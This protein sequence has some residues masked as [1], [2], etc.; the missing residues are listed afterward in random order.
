MPYLVVSK[1]CLDKRGYF[2]NSGRGNHL[3]SAID[4]KKA[5]EISS[6]TKA[7]CLEGEERG[8]IQ[9]EQET[10]KPYLAVF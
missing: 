1:S 8:L 9:A 6:K 5:C 4:L 3:G 2:Q 10:C 7:T